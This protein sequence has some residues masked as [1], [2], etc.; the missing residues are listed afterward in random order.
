MKRTFV[1]LAV[2]FF[3]GTLASAQA[4]IPKLSGL[5]LLE[6]QTEVAANAFSLQPSELNRADYVAA[7]EKLAAHV[8]MPKLFETFVFEGNPKDPACLEKV[9][10]LTEIDQENP[11]AICIR[12]GTRSAN[13]AV[14]FEAQLVEVFGPASRGRASAP[15]DHM[16]IG[17]AF[18]LAQERFSEEIRKT[19]EE[20]A[21]QE[22]LLGAKSEK[23]AI[24]FKNKTL[25]PLYSRLLKASC[26]TS[27]LAFEK[28]K[29]SDPPTIFNLG[30]TPT[31]VPG[32]DAARLLERLDR[33]Y[34]KATPTSVP[35]HSERKRRIRYISESCK[36]AAEAIRQRDPK[37]AAAVC[38]I[39][40]S[41]SARCLVAAIFERQARQE[42][43]KL[44]NKGGS[45]SGGKNE[46]NQGLEEF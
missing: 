36:K 43:R 28:R 42:E 16:T 24:E 14:T 8:C 25:R 3:A 27:R 35:D 46:L 5:K 4:E 30:P 45:A 21:A 41:H 38:S 18:K 23:E 22:A 37:N 40:G 7:L 31:P 9:A 15:E 34:K 12:D 17:L 13:C 11:L 10:K 20:L 29:M 2:L 32:S 39:Y 33:A 1:I 19:W 26:S 44:T 6:W